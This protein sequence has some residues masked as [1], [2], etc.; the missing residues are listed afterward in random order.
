[1]DGRQAPGRR[2]STQDINAWREDA[3]DAMEQLK[4]LESQDRM[5]VARELLNS[6]NTETIISG[7]ANSE[8]E[9]EEGE[10]FNEK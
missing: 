7:A 3:E 4:G 10:A 5:E 6:I 1:M 2:V 9:E 8:E